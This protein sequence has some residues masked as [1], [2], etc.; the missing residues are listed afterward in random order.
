MKR[1]FISFFILS[2]VFVAGSGNA[3]IDAKQEQQTEP[4][5]AEYNGDMLLQNWGIIE[6][7]NQALIIFGL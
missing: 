5:N 4:Y 6:L 3:A 2:L 7:L 1:F